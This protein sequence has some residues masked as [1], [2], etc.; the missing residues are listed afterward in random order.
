[1]GKKQRSLGKKYL[2]EYEVLIASRYHR[3]EWEKGVV[4]ATFVG[5]ELSSILCV[6][7]LIMDDSL[8]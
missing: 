4:A 7:D 3:L 1:M 5:F 2:L 6:V 8:V